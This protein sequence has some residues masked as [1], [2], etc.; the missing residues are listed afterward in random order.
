MDELASVVDELEN[1]LGVQDVE[2]LRELSAFLVSLLS[3]NFRFATVIL[4][5]HWPRK[6]ED[7][8]YAGL[9]IRKKTRNTLF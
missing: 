6:R 4:K 7:K 1:T 9:S 5:R 8:N 2:D 3:R